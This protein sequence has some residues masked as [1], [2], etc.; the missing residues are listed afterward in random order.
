MADFLH[1]VTAAEPAF[2]WKNGEFFEVYK[3]NINMIADIALEA[4]EVAGAVMSM[5]EFS[6]NSSWVGKATDLK[7]LLENFVDESVRR[8]AAWPKQAN[9]LSARLKRCGTNL[10]KKGID[11]ERGKSGDRYISIRKT[12]ENHD[13]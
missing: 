6:K 2:G 5:V 11:I 9:A 8:S 4:D 7:P 1:L 13:Q 10:R 3:E 12:S